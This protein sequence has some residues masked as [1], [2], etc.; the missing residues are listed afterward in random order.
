MA[1]SI[2][3][4]K[5]R[6]LCFAPLVDGTMPDKARAAFLNLMTP[7]YVPCKLTVRFFEL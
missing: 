5:K 6:G 1:G 3:L 4:G 7:L 2:F